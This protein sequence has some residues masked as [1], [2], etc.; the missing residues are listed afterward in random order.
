[1]TDIIEDNSEDENLE[2][3]EVPK[4]LKEIWDSLKI[5]VESLKSF[6]PIWK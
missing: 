5:D 2:V 3:L 6:S 1:M 4:W